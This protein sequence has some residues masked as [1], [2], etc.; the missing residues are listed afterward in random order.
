MS[1]EDVAST[2]ASLVITNLQNSR[3]HAVAAVGV[4]V[5]FSRGDE[6]SSIKIHRCVHMAQRCL[7]VRTA[8][9]DVFVATAT[10]AAAV[11]ASAVARAGGRHPSVC[12]VSGVDENAIAVAGPNP[13]KNNGLDRVDGGFLMHG[14]ADEAAIATDVLRMLA[15][16]RD[17]VDARRL[18]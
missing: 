6:K 16:A 10:T 8:E 13:V 3:E 9:A 4:V 17:I 11:A 14:F 1:G 7:R 2:V 15:M 12:V 5:E 18:S